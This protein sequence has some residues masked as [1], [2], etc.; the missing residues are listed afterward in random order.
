MIPYTPETVLI[1]DDS[2][3]NLMVLSE[4][5]KPFYKVKVA[6]GGAKALNLIASGD[7]PDLI[8]LDIMMPDISGYDVCKK[9]K[10]DPMTRNIPI[11]FVTA[12]SD[13]TNEEEGLHLGAVDYITKPVNSSIVLARVNTQITLLRNQHNL[14]QKLQE[15]TEEIVLTRMEVIRQLGRAAEFKDNETGTHILRMSAYA[16]LIA[17]KIGLDNAR[18]ELIY[19]S[20]PMHD[21]GKIGTPDAVLQKP[22]PLT[23]EEWEVIRKHPKQGADIIGNHHSLLLQTA[24]VVSLTHHE[25]FDGTGYPNGIKGYD[26]P[27]AGRIVAIADVFDALT[28]KR[29]YKDA[30]SIERAVEYLL[31]QKG[32]HFDGELVDTFLQHMDEI[33]AIMMQFKD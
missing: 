14:E 32:K 18:T 10:N 33:Q 26:I 17:Q 4:I 1:V 20:A 5:L 16:K 8:L 30:W 31:A 2:P 22:G 15:R 3:E 23:P 19:L 25:R 6:T 13:Y 27:L 11:I 28:S 9:L 24:R 7:I 12:L 29:P 21:I